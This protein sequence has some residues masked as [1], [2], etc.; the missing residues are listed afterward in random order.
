MTVSAAQQKEYRMAYYGLAALVKSDFKA[1]RG[2]PKGFLLLLLYRLAHFF[3]TAPFYL[4]PLSFIYHVFYKIITEFV[5]GFEIPW[6]CEIG[7]SARIFH[8]IGLVVHPS[9]RIG[10]HVVLRQG[11]TIGTK[12]TKSDAG[13][14]TIGNHVDI[15]AS[16]L[17]LGSIA[18]GDGAAIGA[19]SVVLKDVPPQGVVAGN[20]ARLI[21]I[22]ESVD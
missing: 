8:G 16:A 4:W 22:K 6:S 9:V 12:Y 3:Y 18:I 14:P 1:N 21:R 13:V 17:I 2:H 15:G 7:P 19:G 10:S 20:P 5:I 11:V